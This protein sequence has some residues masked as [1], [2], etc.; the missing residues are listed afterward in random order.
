[1]KKATVKL[2]ALS[3]AGVMLVGC[4]SPKPTTTTTAVAQTATT[5][6]S[7]TTEAKGETKSPAEEVVLTYMTQQMPYPKAVDQINEALHKVHPEITLDIVHVADNYETTVKT[8]FAAGDAPDLFDWNGYL[9]NKTFAEAGYFLDIT[10]D[11]I[12]ERVMEQFKS[13]GMYDGKVY[14]IPTIAQASGLIYNKDAFEK[15][16][17]AEVPKT[18]TELKAACEKLNA[19]GITPF[20]TGFKDVW[21]AHQMFWNVCGPNVGD[22]NTWH[23]EM[24]AGTASFLNDK[25]DAAFELIDIAVDNTFENPLS[26]DAAN[27]SNKLATGEAAMCFQGVWQY[28]EFLKSNPDVNLGLAPI[29]VS[30]NPEDATMEY[31][32]QGIVFAAATGK[33]T[34]EAKKVM[35]WFI[36]DEGVKL[37]GEI[38]QQA[39]PINC[40]ITVELNPLAKDGDAF[41]KAGGKTVGFIKTFWPSGLTTEVGKQLQNYIAEVMTKEEFFKAIDAAFVKLSGS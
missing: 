17:I 14:G 21:V 29:P 15:A 34:E 23:D 25:T 24:A 4:S 39:S 8:K 40:D 27:M 10:D 26:S 31:E 9:A 38:N 3:M 1:M 13:S 12:N 36:S 2:L 32:A 30:E 6:A 7:E 19:A 33:H 18:I 37:V 16:G 11:N 28:A 22:F 35:A 41:V 5:Q 20:A